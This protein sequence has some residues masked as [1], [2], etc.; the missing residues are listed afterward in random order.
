MQRRRER[1]GKQRSTQS[2]APLQ[3]R[4]S[5]GAWTAFLNRRNYW[6]HCLYWILLCGYCSTAVH[7]NYSLRQNSSAVVSFLYLHFGLTLLDLLLSLGLL[8]PFSCDRNMRQSSEQQQQT[9]GG[10]QLWNVQYGVWGMMMNRL[11][12]KWTNVWPRASRVERSVPIVE[13]WFAK[14]SSSAL[15]SARLR[16]PHPQD[17]WSSRCKSNSCWTFLRARLFFF[18]I[19]SNSFATKSPS[20]ALLW[21]PTVLP[22]GT[23]NNRR[24]AQEVEGK[25]CE[26]HDNLR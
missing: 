25:T 24:V 19:V 11:R 9:H 18:A 26:Q 4:Q 2:A 20:K 14:P 13:C 17:R 12:R 22:R 5:K 6:S 7:T 3:A 10:G 8:F 15:S 16:S 21:G 1:P 23:C